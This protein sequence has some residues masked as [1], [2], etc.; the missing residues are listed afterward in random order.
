MFGLP[1]SFAAPLVLAGLIALP[2][3]WLLLR[4]TPPAARRRIAFPPLKIMADMMARRESPARTPWWL[5]AL[6]LMIAALLILAAAGPVLNPTPSL[7]GDRDAPV[8]MI[9]DNGA[10]A[11]ADWRQRAA[12]ALEQGEAIAREGRS[13]GVLATATP[14]AEIALEAPD[15]RDRTLARDDLP[16]SFSSSGSLAQPDRRIFSP[17]IPMR[18]SSGSRMG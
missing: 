13:I 16:P 11:A 15:R 7:D 14:V 6:R 8:L 1:L 9:V 12:I 4:V 5:L 2:A 17:R 10:G 18:R 3:I